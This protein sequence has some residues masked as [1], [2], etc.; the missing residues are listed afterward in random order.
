MTEPTRE[1][2][3]KV[4]YRIDELW[5][6]YDETGDEHGPYNSKEEAIDAVIRYCVTVLGEKEV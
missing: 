1:N 2:S 5:F 4:V 3:A 6:F